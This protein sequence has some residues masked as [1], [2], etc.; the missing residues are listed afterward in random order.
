MK[1]GVSLKSQILEQ[2]YIK[3]VLGLFYKENISVT[4]FHRFFFFHSNKHNILS[5]EKN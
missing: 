5:F 1:L 3:T 4:P 2:L